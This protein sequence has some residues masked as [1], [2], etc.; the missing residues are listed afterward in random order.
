MAGTVVCTEHKKQAP[1]RSVAKVMWD[2][3][4]SAGGAAD[5]TTTESFDG[6]ILALA[7]IPNPDGTINCWPTDNYDIVIRD[8][9][10]LDVAHAAGENRDISGEEADDEAALGAVSYSTLT[11][12]VTNAG[13]AKKGRIAI[14]IR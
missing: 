14:W 1:L 11:L 8:A 6:Q 2:W 12:A 5:S 9:D 7:T 3:T 13:A 10:G 4:S